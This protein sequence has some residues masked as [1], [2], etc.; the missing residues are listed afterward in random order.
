VLISLKKNLFY[1]KSS[2]E[3][4]DIDDIINKFYWKLLKK[5]IKEQ[6]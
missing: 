6:Y 3:D 4:E 2:Q 1:V 5:Y